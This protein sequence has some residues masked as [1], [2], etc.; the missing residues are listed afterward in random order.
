MSYA[1]KKGFKRCSGIAK[2]CTGL[3]QAYFE[4]DLFEHLIKYL[5]I[6]LSLR[7]NY[8][9]ETFAKEWKFF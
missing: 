5:W 7:D 4:L 3:S 6:R 9:S 1:S 8:E 2:L